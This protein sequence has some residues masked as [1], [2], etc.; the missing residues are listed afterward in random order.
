MGALPPTVDPT[1]APP[2][3]TPP[4]PPV[5]GAVPPPLVPYSPPALTATPTPQLAA[6][7]PPGLNGKPNPAA[8]PPAVA[9]RQRHDDK[10]DQAT[11]IGRQVLRSQQQPQNS[12]SDAFTPP[13][14]APQETA[15]LDPVTKQPMAVPQ[16]AQTP[17]TPAQYVAPKKGL[18]YLALGLGLL[19]PGAPIAKAAAGFAQGLQQGAQNSYQR[20]E[21]QAEQQYKVKQ[22]Q[23]QTDFANASAKYGAASEEAHRAFIN[24]QAQFGVDEHNAE[25][26]WQQQQQLRQRGI[27]PKTNKPFVLPKNLAT[28]P[29]RGAGAMTYAQ[30]ESAQARFYTGL[31]ATDQAASH[32]KAA[33]DYVTQARQQQTQAAEF[34]RTVY[35]QSHE[36]A[37]S[38]NAQANEWARHAD[39]EAHADARALLA[40]GRQRNTFR[41]EAVRLG[42][43]AD[44][45]WV[46]AIQPEQ[47]YNPDGTVSA[48][49]KPAV[50]SDPNLK[51]S[52]TQAFLQISR[53]PDPEGLAAHLAS[54]FTGDNPAAATAAQILNERGAAAAAARQSQ[55]LPI[56][57]RPESYYE[58]VEAQ[59]QQALFKRFGLNPNDPRVKSALDKATAAGQDP[60]DPEILSAIKKDL[61]APRHRPAPSAGQTFNRA[62]QDT[63]S[64]PPPM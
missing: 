53:S 36:D 2:A 29:P 16:Q 9:A 40:D 50:I 31:G 42:R 59:A 22:A 8:V 43:Q 37:R 6:S 62:L 7:L 19:F 34:A 55:A 52:L 17:F 41:N 11:R 44:V 3:Q 61:N 28:P 35:V 10:K 45:D 12:T 21:Q 33:E 26:K 47:T 60:S 63:L 18:E 32:A 24:A 48:V 15:P 5:A 38:A 64:N 30:W 23:A 46:K 25:F 54:K 56:F 14:K 20:R 27:D 4:P 51:K 1:L 49:K 58:N 13:T 57:A 39:T